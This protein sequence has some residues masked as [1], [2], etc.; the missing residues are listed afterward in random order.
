VRSGAPFGFVKIDDLRGGFE[1]KDELMNAPRDRA[2]GAD[3]LGR[4]DDTFGVNKPNTQYIVDDLVRAYN[5]GKIV[6]CRFGK[7]YIVNLERQMN[8]QIGN[9][10]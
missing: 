5:E 10:G 8:C 2:G 7:Q 6:Y 3:G 1:K 9:N 4:K